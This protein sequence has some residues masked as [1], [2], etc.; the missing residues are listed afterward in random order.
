MEKIGRHVAAK[1]RSIAAE[2]RTKEQAEALER[3]DNPFEMS[4][5]RKEKIKEY[6]SS[7]CKEK[8]KKSLTGA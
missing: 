5:E 7:L 4:E 1:I 3:F 8:P 2:D 6:S